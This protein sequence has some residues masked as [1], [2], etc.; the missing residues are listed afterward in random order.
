MSKSVYD[1]SQ[2]FY[3]ERDITDPTPY[4]GASPWRYDDCECPICG[5]G[6]MRNEGL[7]ALHH[8]DMENDILI[9]E[10]CLYSSA[11]SALTTEYALLGFLEDIGFEVEEIEPIER[12]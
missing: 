11:E 4:E 12:D 6:F 5:Q 1:H 2:F 3:A 10:S 8:K 9:H 7:L